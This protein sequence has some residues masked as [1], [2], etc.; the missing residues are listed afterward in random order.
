MRF[1]NMSFCGR[2]R[3]TLGDQMQLIA[4]DEIYRQMGLS[5]ERDIVYV[6][7]NDL[8]TYGGEEILLPISFSLVDYVEKGWASRFSARIKPLFLGL[9]LARGFL[10]PEE[11][12]FFNQ[13]GPIGCRDERTYETLRKYNVPSYLAGCVTCTLP[14]RTH[15]PVRG[16]VFLVDA[17]DAASFYLPDDW[18]R[19]SVRL[20]H[21]VDQCANPKR[22]AESLLKRYREEASL[23][24]TS[25]LHCATPCA[26]MGIPVILVKSVV[27]YRFSW[28]DK[29][30]PIFRV[31]DLANFREIPVPVDMGVGE[32]LRRLVMRRLDAPTAWLDD[33]NELTRFWMD[34]TRRPYDLDCFRPYKDFL[35]RYFQSGGRRYS[36]WGLTQMSEMIVEYVRMSYPDA[37]LASVYDKFRRVRFCGLMSKSP[38]ELI[39][40]GALCV[41]TMSASADAKAK[42]C[43]K[44]LKKED[45]CLME[46]YK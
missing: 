44:V 33:F 12:V 19:N 16:K 46:I 5:L 38:D 3:Q 23:V 45:V 39:N 13:N 27:S 10:Y 18:N 14:Q 26:A 36:I 28:I 34:R 6:D 21:F 1:A 37:K 41:T 32:S 11:V 7:K 17:P 29:L 43:E 15:T 22:A 31:E 40:D 4:L 20:S 25:L 9:T 2:G 24:I 30:L 8:A 42:V 35:D